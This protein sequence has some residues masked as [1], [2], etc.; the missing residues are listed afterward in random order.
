MFSGVTIGKRQLF[1]LCVV[2]VV[3]TFQG[4]ITVGLLPVY[5][6]RLGEDPGVTGLF[7]SFAFLTVTI[8]NMA[9]GWASDRLGA[10]KP[11][12]LVAC[13]ASIPAALVM[14]Q[15]T[16]ISGLTLTTG[17][18]WFPG[19]MAVGMV[20]IIAAHSTVERER[21]KVFGWL[22]LAAGI[23]GLV[24]GVVA[25]PIAERWGFPTLFVVMA[26]TSAAMF[27]AA[28]F[29]EDEH[30]QR[31]VGETRLR[32]NRPADERVS[33]GLPLK[34]LLG[35]N[36]LARLANQVGSLAR[37]L[38]MIQVGFDAAEVS[39][40]I[41]VSA[42]VTLPLPLALGWLSDR[43]G[44]TVLLVVCNAISVV[45]LVLLIP[46]V[47]LWQF[48]LSATLLA[49]PQAANG[50]AQAYAADLTPKMVIGRGMSLFN[51]TGLAAGILGLSAAGYVMET[52]GF[53]STLLLTACLPL[54]AIA[55]LLRVRTRA[56]APELESP[57]QAET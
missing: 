38:L 56:P 53:S 57:A 28:I 46:A 13:A 35:A 4:T 14:T 19:G 51:T 41:A 32:D 8:G 49:I 11:L 24:A 21:G 34:W 31:A 6:V 7:V 48:W 30:R 55:L 45:S 20:T 9:G 5:A 23:G 26:A 44:R 33:I 50:V 15:A 10:R 47:V 43:A 36:F 54:V 22:A 40:A 17:L 3:I 1:L 29:V 37:P 18:L 39:T 42:A 16:D 2:N 25:G 52:I 27:V 12:L